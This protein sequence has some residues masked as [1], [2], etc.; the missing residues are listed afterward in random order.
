MSL[1]LGKV[2]AVVIVFLSLIVGAIALWSD[3]PI[4]LKRAVFQRTA[5]EPTRPKFD[6]PKK[7]VALFFLVRDQNVLQEEPREIE[8]GITTTEEAKRALEELAK[9]PE[10]DLAPTL[11]RGV[12][13]RNLFIDSSGTAYADFNRELNG[14]HPGG[15]QEELYTVFSIVDTL[16]INFPKIRR[17]QLLVEGVEI[18]TLTGNVDTRAPLTPRFAF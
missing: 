2:A 9:G 12:Q 18:P 11:P 13:V 1:S 3:Q 5:S 4:I 8:A 17:V 15:A 6:G 10:S 14:G 7:T 16:A